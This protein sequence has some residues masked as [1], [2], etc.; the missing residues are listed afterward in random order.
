[1]SWITES[2]LFCWYNKTARYY[3]RWWKWEQYS[4][5]RTEKA[6]FDFCVQKKKKRDW[7]LIFSMKALHFF[8]GNQS[9]WER[10]FWFSALS[11]T[12]GP[13]LQFMLTT[14][15]PDTR[16]P[17]MIIHHTEGMWVCIQNTGIMSVHPSSHHRCLILVRVAG[18]AG[19]YTR[20]TCKAWAGI[21]LRTTAAPVNHAIFHHHLQV[22]VISGAIYVP[23]SFIFL[24]PCSTAAKPKLEQAHYT[25]LQTIWAVKIVESACH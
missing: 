3:E 6:L 7:C 20:R 25:V 17:N 22:I 2:S 11:A 13:D 19:E 4:P 9:L 16:R 8:C 5:F 23:S 18:V 21:K 14:V 10:I 12:P 24:F 1:M 15:I